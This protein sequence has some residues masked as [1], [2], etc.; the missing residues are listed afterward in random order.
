MDWTAQSIAYC[1]RTD[2]TYWSEPVNAITN[3]SF[4]IAAAI[5]AYRLRGQRLP[6]AWALVAVLAAIGI[7]S[8]LWHTHATRWAG[9]M[10][11]LP[12]LF[13]I[14][15][16]VYAASRDYLTLNRWLALLPVVLFIPYAIAFSR[17]V[18]LVIAG[19]GANAIYASVAALIL[20]YAA[21]IARS[22]PATAR[23]LAIGAAILALSLTFR[24][25]DEPVCDVFPIGTHFMWHVLN[26]VMLGWMI[27]VY[28]RHMT[29]RA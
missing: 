1:E 9:T 28:R 17:G 10:D 21:I 7:G 16:Y 19:A 25:L 18:G 11:V 20:I 27:E 6:L 15:I 14:L 13:F 23:G 22:A 2:F 24:A 4:L 29:A 26:G 5:M 8:Y 3:A 12:I